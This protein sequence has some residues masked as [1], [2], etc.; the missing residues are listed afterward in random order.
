MLSTQLLDILK[1]SISTK[2]MIMSKENNFENLKKYSHAVLEDVYNSAEN[3]FFHIER[4]Q[5][6]LEGDITK[7]VIFESKEHFMERLH[8]TTLTITRETS[9]EQLLKEIDRVAELI[10]DNYS[11]ISCINKYVWDEWKKEINPLDFITTQTTH[12]NVVGCAIDDINLS[13]LVK[14]ASGIISCSLVT[15]QTTH[16][17]NDRSI[18]L[19][20]PCDESNTLLMCNGDLNTGNG[21]PDKIHPLSRTLED[22]Y[23]TFYKTSFLGRGLL[24]EF[25]NPGSYFANSVLPLSIMRASNDRDFKKN[26]CNEIV[27]R[28]DT[29]PYGI[30]CFEESLEKAKKLKY[31]LALLGWELDVYKIGKEHELVQI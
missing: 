14:T 31:T 5:K 4:L 25:C 18:M 21:R 27:L 28:G 11:E 7:D 10:A 8:D 15:E 19:L 26:V 22:Y 2:L 20:Y 13:S 17:Y 30:L 29:V 16:F 1:L 9:V 6:V 12:W 23:T 24:P 3:Y